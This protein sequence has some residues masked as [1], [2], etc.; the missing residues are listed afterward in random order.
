MIQSALPN[1]VEVFDKGGTLIWPSV[2]ACCLGQAE[3][4]IK[5]GY[6]THFFWGRTQ[7]F[8]TW[9]VPCCMRCLA[10]FNK[11][12]QWAFGC[13]W[14]PIWL[15]VIMPVADILARL[16]PSSEPNRPVSSLVLSMILGAVLVVL[17]RRAVLDA[18]RAMQSSCTGLE[19]A[20]RYM[21]KNKYNFGVAR[22]PKSSREPHTFVF[23][24]S[25]YAERFCAVN[26]GTYKIGGA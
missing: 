20:V 7:T 11:A 18:R 17:R 8:S 15:F 14:I 4:S 3:Y 13:L 9:D 24:N 23:T 25:E 16:I 12:R 19:F 21:K 5:V 22:M 1:Y 10:H 6:T 26:Q 2:C